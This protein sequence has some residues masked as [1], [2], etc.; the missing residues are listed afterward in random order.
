[1]PNEFGVTVTDEH[2]AQREALLD[3]LK[4]AETAYLELAES[5]TA[6]TEPDYGR[7]GYAVNEAAEEVDDDLIQLFADA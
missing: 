5:L 2:R 6:G 3:L 4:Q 7:G 1:M